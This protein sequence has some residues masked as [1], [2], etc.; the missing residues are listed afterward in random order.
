MKKLITLIVLGVLSLI[1][2]SKGYET[3]LENYYLSTNTNQIYRFHKSSFRLE[4]WRGYSWTKVEKIGTTS[5]SLL[6]DNVTYQYEVVKDTV[7]LTNSTSNLN[8]IYDRSQHNTNGI[9]KYGTL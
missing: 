9:F 2:C 1:S 5:G 7:K 4:L 6:I 3:P 8:L